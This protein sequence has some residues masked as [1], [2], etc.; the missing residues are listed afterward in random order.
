MALFAELPDDIL[1]AILQQA[2]LQSLFT[3]QLVC[4]SIYD[5]IEIYFVSIAPAVARNTFGDTAPLLLQRPQKYDM[6]WLVGL[7][8]RYLA[9]VIVDRYGLSGAA[10]D[11]PMPNNGQTCWRIPATEAGG[12]DLIDHVANGFKVMMK[13]ALISKAVYRIPP[14]MMPVEIRTIKGIVRKRSVPWVS[15][16]LGSITSKTMESI[17]LRPI[18]SQHHYA[19]REKSKSEQKEDS[20]HIHAIEKYEAVILHRRKE[21][22]LSVSPADTM[23]YMLMLPIFFSCLCRN[24][25]G[26]P[27]PRK[28]KHDFFDWGRNCDFRGHRVETGNSWVNWWILHQG[29][30]VFWQQWCPPTLY[31]ED[32]KSLVR[33]LLLRSWDERGYRQIE[34]ETK[35]TQEIE[36]FLRSRMEVIAPGGRTAR[37]TNPLRHFKKYVKGENGEWRTED[38]V[39]VEET[40]DDIPYF[41]DFQGD[42]PLRLETAAEA[43]T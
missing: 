7:I 11:I 38:D 26:T 15:S 10:E 2:D 3:L 18:L 12:K 40:L 16:K 14:R 32:K 22:L 1:C 6:Q 24:Q 9:T 37:A 33:T 27:Y 25:D 17:V 23:D 28:F 34:A 20:T 19:P 4:K 21:Y 42:P 43:R 5:M 30:L 35:A 36:W 29:P 8:P 39:A 13:L 41:I 31:Q